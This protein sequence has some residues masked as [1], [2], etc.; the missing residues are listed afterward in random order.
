VPEQGFPYI[1]VTQKQR[2][3]LLTCLPAGL[4]TKISYASIRGKHD[5][6]GAVQRVLNSRRI[7]SIKEFTRNG[8]DYPN[9]IVLNWVN[10]N[11]PVQRKDGLLFVPGVPRAAQ[12]IDGQHRVA[13]PLCMR[14]DFWEPLI[15]FDE[16]C[17]PTVTYD[18]IS[19]Y[20][21][22]RNPSTLIRDILFSRK[23]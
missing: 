22:C 16:N 19:N 6:A 4:L 10:K 3:F 20:N 1:S 14:R 11:N 5:E 21:Q 7:T 17:S 12:L 8:G 15:F 23:K 2:Q 18:I 9:S 13:G